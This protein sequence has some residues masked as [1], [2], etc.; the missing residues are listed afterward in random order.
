MKNSLEVRES[1]QEKN[2]FGRE[3][4]IQASWWGW[5]SIPVAHW[6]V[7]KVAELPQAIAGYQGPWASHY[8]TSKTCRNTNAP[9]CP[10]C[11]P[12]ATMP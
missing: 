1:T 11:M 12:F 3:V 9:G 6:M 7:E 4:G 5:E 10:I 8:S 2:K